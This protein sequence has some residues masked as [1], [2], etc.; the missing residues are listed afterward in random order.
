MN[1][2]RPPPATE[3]DLG[4]G[5]PPELPEEAPRDQVESDFTPLLR[6]LLW[7]GSGRVVEVALVDG[8]GECVDYC[9]LSPPDEARLTAAWLEVLSRAMAPAVRRLGSGRLLAFHLQ[10]ER[11]DLAAVRV[12]DEYLLTARALRGGMDERWREAM[13]RAA[14][15]IRA[16][17]GLRP[18]SW[19]P[20][21]EGLRVR[22]RG[23]DGGP[24]WLWLGGRLE[25]IEAVVGHWEEP[26]GA[27]GEVLRGY[28]VR[29]REGREYS[30]LHDPRTNRWF[31]GE[32]A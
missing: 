28:R 27:I 17:A 10:G 2:S 7:L 5:L 18:P 14:R 26:P 30:V 11:F 24:G 21:R 9:S 19:E 6:G 3:G 8:E 13:A 31:L 29:T 20:G 32:E 16:V 4:S 15:G 25:R 12:D 1:T 22:L 23:A